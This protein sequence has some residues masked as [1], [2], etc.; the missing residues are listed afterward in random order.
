MNYF[1]QHYADFRWPIDNGPAPGFRVPQWGALHA[2]AGHFSGSSE[3]AIIT[4][5][6]GSG[7]TAVIMGLGFLL[8]AKRVLVLTP[9]RIVR[10]QITEEFRLLRVL[11]ILGA[12]DHT[13]GGW[14][15]LNSWVAF[16]S[17]FWR[18]GDP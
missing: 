12:V 11:K 7:K 17:R 10:E 3:P 1:A 13:L 15:L 9:S 14:Q 18:V 2:L 4:M 6:T 8:R 16:P 5:P